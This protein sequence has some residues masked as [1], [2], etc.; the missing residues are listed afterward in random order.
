MA[1]IAIPVAIHLDVIIAYYKVSHHS[2]GVNEYC[3]IQFSC[4][5][6]IIQPSCHGYTKTMINA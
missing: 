3:L 2:C 6:V 5:N 1:G 4:V